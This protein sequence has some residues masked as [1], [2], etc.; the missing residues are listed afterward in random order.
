MSKRISYLI[1]VPILLA[2]A[3]A[4][5]LLLKTRDLKILVVFENAGELGE[6]TK[7]VYGGKIIG[8]VKGVREEANRK[9]V[10]TLRIHRQDASSINQSSAFIIKRPA[11]GTPAYIYVKVLDKNAPPLAKGDK[12]NGYSSNLDFVLRYGRSVIEEAEE[13]IN[14]IKDGVR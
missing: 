11:P 5:T 8:E 13:T 10:V 1:V 3:I 4:L 6:G 14:M 9:R 2:S 12:L 7:V